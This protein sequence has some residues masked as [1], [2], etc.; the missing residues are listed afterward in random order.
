MG[1]I[2][3]S[4]S[5]REKLLAFQRNEM[6]GAEIYSRLGRAAGGRNAAILARI[7]RDEARHQRQLKGYTGSVVGPDRPKVFFYYWV[8][9]LLGLT[10]G[11][12]LLELQEGKD[13]TAYT[14]AAGNIPELR[15]IARDE[16]RHERMLIG[17]IEEK[18]L[19]HVGSIVLGLNDA[20]VEIA[21]TLAGLTIAFQNARL[22]AA[23]GA[24]FGIAGAMSM[25]ASEYLSKKSEGSEVTALGAS[26]YTGIAY[27]T[28]LVLLVLPYVVFPSKYVALA[29]MLVTGLLII[30]GYNFY[31]SVA[32]ELPFWRRFL[33]TAALSMGVS[34]LSFGVGHL[35]RAVFGIDV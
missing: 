17:M 16:D 7:A 1:A 10:F 23:V 8:A 31:L 21:G 4:K 29:V 9:R 30:L 19:V 33:E 35:I 3:I 5:F 24:I 28:T 27:V 13:E 6:T 15:R 32:K 34:F 11:I 22:I 14:R 18:K 26:V 12:K 20:L 25:S 2:K